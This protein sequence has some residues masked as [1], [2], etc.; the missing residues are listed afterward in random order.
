MV[1]LG[2]ESVLSIVSTT[3]YSSGDYT[4]GLGVC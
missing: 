4:V 1:I 2:E 3:W